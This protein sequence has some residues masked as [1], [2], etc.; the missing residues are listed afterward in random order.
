MTIATAKTTE[1]TIDLK[2]FANWALGEINSNMKRALLA[3]FIVGK[4]LGCLKDNHQEWDFFDLTYQNK[5]IEV[6]SSGYGTPPFLPT[7]DVPK[8]RFDIAPRT[9]AWSNEAHDFVGDGSPQRSSDLYIFA[10]TLGK[11]AKEF[12]PQK[13]RQWQFHVA[14]TKTLNAEFGAQKTISGA[15]LH[16]RFG[17]VY[18][19]ELKSTVDHAIGELKP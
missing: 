12:Q 3:E 6:K 5:K 1:P 10:A 7:K 11:D 16:N 8:P 13:L 9:W 19:G 2:E 4:T 14:L 15:V 18:Y 17:T